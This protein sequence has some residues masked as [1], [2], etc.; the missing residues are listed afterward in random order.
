MERLKNL[1]LNLI[2]PGIIL[3]GF[4]G[5]I[6]GIIIF[7]YKLLWNILSKVSISYYGYSNGETTVDYNTLVSRFNMNSLYTLTELDNYC[8][9]LPDGT[10]EKTALRNN[11]D[12]LSQ[13][14]SFRN[15]LRNEKSEIIIE[16]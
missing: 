3:S 11:L 6:V 4:I 8:N 2:L 9:N 7:F 14:M 10:A 12:Q 5:V 13:N 16:E 15:V 1:F